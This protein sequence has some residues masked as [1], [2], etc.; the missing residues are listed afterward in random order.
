M[1]EGIDISDK[2][3]C[4]RKKKYKVLNMPQRDEKSYDKRE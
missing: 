4:F 3:D 2:L 1:N